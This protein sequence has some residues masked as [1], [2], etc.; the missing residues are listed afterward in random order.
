MTPTLSKAP[1]WIAAVCG[2]VIVAAGCGSPIEPA[3]APDEP[4]TQAQ[5]ELAPSA[6]D[7][8]APQPAQTP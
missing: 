2:L 4:T 1:P 6:Q 3:T 5:D 8:P 7:E